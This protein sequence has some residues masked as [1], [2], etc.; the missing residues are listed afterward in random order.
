MRKCKPLI[1]E[2]PASFLVG[3]KS[4][5]SEDSE[6]SHIDSLESEIYASTQSESTQLEVYEEVNEMLELI[7]M[8][9]VSTDIILAM[10][11]DVIWLAALPI[12]GLSVL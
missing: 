1:D 12:A 9:E 10:K 6:L 7:S 8:D 5:V 2:K 11:N 3:R 4:S